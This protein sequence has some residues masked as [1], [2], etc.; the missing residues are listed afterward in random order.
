MSQGAMNCPFLTLTARPVRP[1]ACTRSVCRAKNAGTCNSSHTS[2]AGPH[3]SCSCTCVV[4]GS[5]VR[6]RT[7]SRVRS[8]SSRP[9]PRN[10]LPEVRLA[11][12]ND[13]L[14]TSGSLSRPASSASD[15]AM[16]KVRSC[17]S[18][19]H[20]PR[21]HN[22]GRPGPQARPSRMA[23]GSMVDMGYP[24]WCG[25]GASRERERPELS[26]LQ[27]DRQP[28]DAG[29]EDEVVLGE[30][31]Q[32]VGGQLDGDVAVAGEVQVGV[33]VLGLGD[34]ADALEE[35]QRRQEVAGPPR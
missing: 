30:P 27:L 9:G 10:D 31:A 5:P 22:S 4:T 19:T 33:V 18:M 2:A 25:S 21:T 11:L 8:P 24:P 28:V 32:G 6:S 1:A 7:A 13:A 20:G 12:S 34:G 23:T 3:C 14:N 29:G 26:R 16:R 17:D 15:S 35:L